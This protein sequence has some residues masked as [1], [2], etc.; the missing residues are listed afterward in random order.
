MLEPRANIQTTTR[1]RETPFSVRALPRKVVRALRRR[2]AQ[3]TPRRNCVPRMAGTC[4]P[5]R[6]V[7]ARCGAR[8][9]RVRRLARVG[10][11]SV[12]PQNQLRFDLWAVLTTNSD[13]EVLPKDQPWTFDTY[14]KAADF[15]AVSR[16]PIYRAGLTV[17]VSKPAEAGR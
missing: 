13:G 11:M 9:L 2:Q 6:R 17:D 16:R 4:R 3:V 14:D 12:G 7:A 10:A 5:S 1:L 15:V 8:R